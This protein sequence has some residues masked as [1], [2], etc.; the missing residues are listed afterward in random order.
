M[1][2]VMPRQYSVIRERKEYPPMFKPGQTF[3]FFGEIP[4]MEGHCIVMDQQTGKMFAGLHIER[5]EEIPD[6]ET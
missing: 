3:I 4:N 6:D 1:D 5:F 2:E